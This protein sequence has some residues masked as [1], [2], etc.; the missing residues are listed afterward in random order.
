MAQV[1]KQH[2]P[3]QARLKELDEQERKLQ[4]IVQSMRADLDERRKRIDGYRERI[5]KFDAQRSVTRS[6]IHALIK[7][8]H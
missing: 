2:E 6:S 5:A 1:E 7:N 4:A 3:R 8:R